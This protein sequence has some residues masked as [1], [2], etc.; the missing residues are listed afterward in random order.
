MS[1]PP[2]YSHSFAQT[3][4]EHDDGATKDPSAAPAP[5]DVDINT[6]AMHDDIPYPETTAE[7]LTHP[8]DFRPLF[9]LIEDAETGDHHHPGIHYVFSDDDPALLTTAIVESLAIQADEAQPQQG[10]ERIVVLDLGPDGKTITDAQSL[11]PD[12]QISN[13]QLSQAP[14]WNDGDMSRR[15][16]SLMLTISGTEGKSRPIQ[17][18]RKGSLDAMLGSVEGLTL[19]YSERLSALDK[20]V[21]KD[22]IEQESRE[23]PGQDEDRGQ[24]MAEAAQ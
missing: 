9:T 17:P 24:T 18:T 14:S 4:D 19:G 11:S 12:W 22:V 3:T 1:P 16:G 23:G 2:E 13:T 8:P 6:Q 5:G 10:E 15:D 20:L 7:E 21:K